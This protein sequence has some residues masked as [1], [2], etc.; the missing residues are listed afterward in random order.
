MTRIWWKL[1]K[2]V[3]NAA[4][5]VK[6][7]LIKSNIIATAWQ[8]IMVVA[9]GSGA[10]LRAE[11]K[12]ALWPF[13]HLSSDSYPVPTFFKQGCVV[14]MTSC[15]GSWRLLQAGSPLDSSA[16]WVTPSRV[17]QHWG[18]KQQGWEL[19]REDGWVGSSGGGCCCCG[20]GDVWGSLFWTKLWDIP[21]Y[22]PERN[23]AAWLP[24]PALS[25]HGSQACGIRAPP[26]SVPSPVR[27]HRGGQTDWDQ[28]RVYGTRPKR[29]TLGRGGCVCG[30][31]TH[32]WETTSLLNRAECLGR[33]LGERE[34]C[35]RN[36]EERY[37]IHDPFQ[38]I[39]ISCNIRNLM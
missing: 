6:M 19:D 37:N 35:R 15:L 9:C 26:A 10:G 24:H 34:R 14:L 31:R 27:L 36:T 13:T 23:W 1:S 33:R 28:T 18:E 12:L 5:V 25:K 7:S 22:W 8:W 17:Q 11:L 21:L 2:K 20:G 32:L 3:Q 29:Q 30:R 16:V 38:D 39:L 4:L